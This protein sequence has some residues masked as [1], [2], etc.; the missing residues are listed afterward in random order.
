M[1]SWCRAAKRC[2]VEGMDETTV[3]VAAL[4]GKLQERAFLLT[5]CFAS[6]FFAAFFVPTG[7][8]IVVARDCT[9]FLGFDVT[10]LFLTVFLSNG[11]DAWDWLRHGRAACTPS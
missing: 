3:F 5:T 7:L 2:N 11:H 4:M 9:A 10:V 6:R 8:R 1:R